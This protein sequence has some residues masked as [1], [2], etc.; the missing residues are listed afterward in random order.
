M[1]N[2]QFDT[3]GVL[4]HDLRSYIRHANRFGTYQVFETAHDE[5]VLGLLDLA[6]LVKE[7]RQIQSD[8][9][10]GWSNGAP[11][12][13][14]SR[15]RQMMLPGLCS[16]DGILGELRDSFISMLLQDGATDKFI[17]EHTGA[18]KRVLQAVRDAQEDPS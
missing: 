12:I 13:H 9:K 8:K 4:V 16:P 11:Q 15:N 2:L 14:S 5:G 1:A 6:S 10:N 3:E 7:L 17:S 18:T